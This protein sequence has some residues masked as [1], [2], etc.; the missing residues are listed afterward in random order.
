MLFII[1]FIYTVFIVSS[2]VATY[3]IHYSFQIYTWSTLFTYFNVVN[4]CIINTVEIFAVAL[5][6][7]ST[8]LFVAV[9]VIEQFIVFAVHY[10]SIAQSNAQVYL[11]V[12]SLVGHLVGCFQVFSYLLIQNIVLVFIVDVQF[13]YAMIT[14][15]QMY[16]L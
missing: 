14:L 15:G 8:G 6:F 5:H 10:E 3:V 2:V 13:F 9:N 7:A 11:W 4:A 1:Y 12:V 16:Q